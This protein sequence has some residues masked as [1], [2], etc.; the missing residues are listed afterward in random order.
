MTRLLANRPGRQMIF[1][2]YLECSKNLQI[3]QTKIAKAIRKNESVIG[4]DGQK[5][6]IDQLFTE[7]DLFKGNIN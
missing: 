7:E 1:N 5:W 6:W 2:T 3:P 4:P